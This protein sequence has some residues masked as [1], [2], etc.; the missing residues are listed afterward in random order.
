MV[1]YAC[2]LCVQNIILQLYFKNFLDKMHRLTASI[3]VT[4]ITVTNKKEKKEKKKCL[5]KLKAFDI[6]MSTYIS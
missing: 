4:R 1:T 2:L 6:T 3:T 5:F